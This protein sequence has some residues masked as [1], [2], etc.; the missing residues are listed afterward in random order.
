[1]HIVVMAWLY[2][3]ALMALTMASGVAG[4][5]FFACVGLAPVLLYGA[6]AARR[7]R[8]RRARGLM[9]EQHVHGADDRHAEAD[10]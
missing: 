4:A 9:R 10:G 2:V 7:I 6:L 3:T 5:A 1:M 8:A